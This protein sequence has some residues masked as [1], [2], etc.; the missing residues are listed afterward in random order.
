MNNNDALGLDR[1]GNPH[2]QCSVP[3]QQQSLSTPIIPASRVDCTQ[4][5]SPHPS[6][7]TT[8]G[9]ETDTLGVRLCKITLL[10]KVA[11]LPNIQSFVTGPQGFLQ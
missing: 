8:I 11:L 1:F 2:D 4:T 7:G 9:L 6:S 3:D 5:A 10:D